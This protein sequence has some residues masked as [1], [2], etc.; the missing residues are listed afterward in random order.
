[1]FGGVV[2]RLAAA[3]RVPNRIAH[4]HALPHLTASAGWKRRA[5]LSLMRR[6]IERFATARLAVSRASG[7]GIFAADWETCSDANVLYCGIDLTLF[8]RPPSNTAIRSELGLPEQAFVVGHVGSF[9]P[10][11]NHEFLVEI[12]AELIVREPC[13]HVLL[14]GDGPERGRIEANVSKLG[15]SEQVHFT[16][17]R[18]DIPELMRGA[19]DVFIL[20]S[21]SEGLPLVGIEAQAAG[22]P[23]LFSNGVTE[24]VTVIPELVRHLSL[25]ASPGEWADALLDTRTVRCSQPEALAQVAAS[26][27]NIAFG[28]ARLEEIYADR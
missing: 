22:L 26:P 24:E 27:F 20:P 12:A 5:Y 4:S 14:V 9:R 15:L 18:S 28:V 25:S 2:M 1:M 3:H 21:L 19:M 11:K 10:V 13:G 16:G 6:W 17:I 7:T 23:T 8:S